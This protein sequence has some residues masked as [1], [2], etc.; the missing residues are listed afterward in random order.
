LYFLGFGILTHFGTGFGYGDTPN[1]WF[2][3]FPNFFGLFY[4]TAMSDPFMTPWPCQTKIATPPPLCGEQLKSR[5]QYP[6]WL[7]FN[8]T[9]AQAS[10]I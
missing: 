8:N 6:P 3:I 7:I 2:K 4:H 9:G 10:V 5:P 1:P